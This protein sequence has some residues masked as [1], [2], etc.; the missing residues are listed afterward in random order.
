MTTAVAI[1][2]VAHAEERVSGLLLER[3]DARAAYVF[4]HG[5]GAGM[6]HP[7]MEAV[8]RAL[9]DR[10][11]ATFRFQFPSMEK[12]LKRPDPP[13]VAQASVRAAVAEAGR[14]FPGLPL[15]AGGKSFGGRMTSQAQA[16]APLPGV[17]GLAFTGFPLHQ[18]GKPSLQR[19]E[20]LVK[21][22]LPMLFLQGTR[23]ALA[24]LDLLTRV[25]E[26]LGAHASL[27][28]FNDADHSFQ[29]R[30]SSGAPREVILSMAD[31]MTAWMRE[32][33]P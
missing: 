8:A 13:A 11:V 33:S 15:F 30:K 26:G 18:A 24:D 27:V 31:A 29:V 5:A 16:Q 12:G 28:T 20:H 7:F 6:R 10:Q 4:A 14:R 3:A 32:R 23:D 1:D 19:A 21:V 9:A 17:V 25:V 22:Q 2:F